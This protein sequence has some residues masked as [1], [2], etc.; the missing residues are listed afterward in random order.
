MS[1]VTSYDKF[2]YPPPF[3]YPA[4]SVVIPLYNAE[5]YIGECL[6]SIL[7]QTFQNFEVIVVDDCSTD[8]SCAIV[9][10]YAE[11]FGG[12]LILAH[13]EKNSGGCALPR[14]KGLNFSRGEYIFFMDADDLFTPTALEEMY[15]LAKNYDADVVHCE[16]HYEANADG[17][18]IHLVMSVF[19]E[20]KQPTFHSENLVERVNFILQRDI[21][22][23]PWCKLVRRNLLT[24]NEILFQKVRPCEDHLWTL[25]IFF[26]ARKYLRVP[27]ANY[28]YR[29][30]DIS[31][32]RGQK[33]P[34]Q[35]MTLWIES[36]IL[37]LKGLDKSLCRI[38]FFKNNLQA[39]FAILNY[40]LTKMFNI[41]LNS[42]LKLHPVAVYDA[43]RQKFGEALGEWDVLVSALVA[44]VDI[45]EK[46]L[47][48]RTM[49]IKQL[50]AELNKKT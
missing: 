19:S 37:G 16:K 47:M 29:Q 35:D 21:W 24:E 14:N 2:K 26:F 30:S 49:Y 10:S 27:N 46:E 9:E 50:E 36:A 11:K 48:K 42:R 4:V 38:N 8:S 5:K 33:T 40:F 34:E 18:N 3:T 44:L 20:I 31:I 12:R 32:T 17:S 39:R 22:G 1:E 28:I 7:N 13:M 23:T 41:S 45:Q 43:T 6:N 25:D 15:T